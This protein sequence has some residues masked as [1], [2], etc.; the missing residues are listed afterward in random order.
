[1]NHK[2]PTLSELA[3]NFM[4]ATSMWVKAGL[5]IVGKTL[6]NYRLS[7]CM[8]CEYWDNETRLGYGKCNAPDMTLNGKKCGCG[9]GKLLMGTGRCPLN[10]WEQPNPN[11]LP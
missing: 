9:K 2:E 4:E 3:Q 5:P 7:A 11:K 6:Y 10:R 8:K 1:M